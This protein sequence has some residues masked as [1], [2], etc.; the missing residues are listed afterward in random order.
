L[1]NPAL[2]SGE[3]ACPPET[4]GDI[5]VYQALLSSLENPS[6]SGHKKLL[7]LTGSGDFDPDFFDLEAAQHR[8]QLLK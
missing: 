4:T 7:E 1:H 3:Q 8:L 6:G 5:H 2:L